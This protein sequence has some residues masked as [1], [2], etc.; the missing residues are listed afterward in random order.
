MLK[1]LQL[2]AA[3]DAVPE[4]FDVIVDIAT[5]LAD[6]GD[7]EQALELAIIVLQQSTVSYETNQTAEDLVAKLEV[8]LAPETCQAVR[9]RALS[10][11]LETTINDL[12]Q[13]LLPDEQGAT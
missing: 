10:R 1:A 7:Q 9:E 8:A 11:N 4:T 2:A 3:I 13:E 12:L 5:L 6:E